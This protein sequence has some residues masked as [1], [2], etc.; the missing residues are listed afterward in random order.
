MSAPAW[1]R[2]CNEETSRKKVGK[3]KEPS[4]TQ[5]LG[6]RWPNAEVGEP[7]GRR[8][9]GQPMPTTDARPLGT[10]FQ[11]IWPQLFFL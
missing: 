4:P 9:T 10:S 3:G 1:P 5:N 7:S 2:P 8:V 6:P 11:V